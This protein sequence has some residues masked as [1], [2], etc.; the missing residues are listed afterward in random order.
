MTHD[1]NT[2]LNSHLSKLKHTMRNQIELELA[3]VELTYAQY[4][5]LATI[6]QFRTQTN[7][8][9]ARNCWVRPQTMIRIVAELKE[10]RLIEEDKE[11]SIGKKKSVKLT[12]SAKKLLKKAHIIIDKL[13]SQMLMNFNQKEIQLFISF[14][15]R[16][17]ENIT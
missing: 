9:I 8:D 13:E 3:Q 11:N 17:Y 7:A 16:S 5:A 14:L 4:S 2:R 10:R 15:D 1:K 12:S 6:E